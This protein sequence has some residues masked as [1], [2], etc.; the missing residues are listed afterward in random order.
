MATL[1]KNYFTGILSVIEKTICKFM[2]D[3]NL[4]PVSCTEDRE[5]CRDLNLDSINFNR[6]V[7]V[8]KIIN[9]AT[10]VFTYYFAL[11]N[12]ANSV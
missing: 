3:D 7:D 8:H 11:D 1:I 6:P 10:H 12:T 4:L 9:D 2:E 5:K